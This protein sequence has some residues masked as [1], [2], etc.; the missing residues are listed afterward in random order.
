MDSI[1]T[2]LSF[3]T[4]LLTGLSFWFTL[5]IINNITDPATNIFLIGQMMN[6]DLLKQD[7]KMGNGLQWRAISSG[8]IHKVVFTSVVLIQI[9][10]AMLLWK[11]VVAYVLVFSEPITVEAIAN[12]V[13]SANTGLIAFTALWICFWCGGMWFGYWMKTPQIQQVHMVLI[14]LS[15][16]TFLILNN[17]ILVK[18]HLTYQHKTSDIKHSIA[19]IR[20]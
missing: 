1:T 12:A 14:I 11:A 5:A 10:V 13:L 17:P 8:T 3:D 16:A 19:N 6:M 2:I 20:R 15:L 18:E 4:L 9:A 7:Q